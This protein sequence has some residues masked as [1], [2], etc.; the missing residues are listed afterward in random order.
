MEL[1][2]KVA[3][4]FLVKYHDMSFELVAAPGDGDSL[5]TAEDEN[6]QSSKFLR[7]NT[8]EVDRETTRLALKQTFLNYPEQFQCEERKTLFQ[9]VVASRESQVSEKT[10][11]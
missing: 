1:C 4:Y 11:K 5:P 8:E 3:L 6:N 10:G 7:R 9:K 2:I